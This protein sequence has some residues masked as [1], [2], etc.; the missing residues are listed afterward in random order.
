METLF[1]N[2]MLLPA[3][4]A[5]GPATDLP[6]APYP[7]AVMSDDTPAMDRP[8]A[9]MDAEEE[10]IPFEEPQKN[11][12]TGSEDVAE[13]SA[14]AAAAAA[15]D[16]DAADAPAP[17]ASADDANMPEVDAAP[18]EEDPALV[19]AV[20]A[21]TTSEPPAKEEEAAAKAAAEAAVD[22]APADDEP[23][24]TPAAAAVA[25]TAAAVPESED[26]DG[27]DKSAPKSAA[28]AADAPAPA[29]AAPTTGIEVKDLPAAVRTRMEEVLVGGE[30]E[31]MREDARL[32]NFLG[33]V[34]EA[35]VGFCAF[36]LL[37][38]QQQYYYLLLLLYC[39]Y[40]SSYTSRQGCSSLTPSNCFARTSWRIGWALVFC[41][42]RTYTHPSLIPSS[43]SPSCPKKRR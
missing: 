5:G 21:P 41:E 16:A 24:G 4:P 2:K 14:A 19:D 27:A 11:G 9:D 13:D 15:P 25:A 26:A 18:L 10:M 6:C 37:R 34:A 29:V 1:E 20:A 43:L 28:D 42:A 40:T 22:A 39:I 31:S 7:L 12:E 30:H 8:A 35:Q 36:V 3:A 38:V 33:E 32:V 23:A 17:D